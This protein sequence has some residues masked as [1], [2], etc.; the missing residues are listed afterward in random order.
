KVVLE[1]EQEFKDNEDTTPPKFIQG[2]RQY[3]DK[4]D[5]SDDDTHIKG[6]AA[7]QGRVTGSVRVLQ[8]I[9]D[10][11]QVQE[12]DILVVPRTDP[13]WTP[14]FA[15]IGGLITETGGVLSH[16]AVVSREY[17]IPAV[18]NIRQ[19]GQK[20][21]TGQVVTLDGNNGTVS[22]HDGE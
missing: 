15:H 22:I 8:R 10:I 14:V 13:G 5:Y 16:G 19:A 9:E 7:S 2:T 1:R 11:P 3:D 21:K 4:M 6:L 12:G 20:L 18:T 17:G